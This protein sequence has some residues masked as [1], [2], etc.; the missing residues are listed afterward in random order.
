MMAAEEPT[1]GTIG[2]PEPGPAGL[3]GLS[4][5]GVSRRRQ[6]VWVLDRLSARLLRVA[7]DPSACQVSWTADGGLVWVE[8]AGRGGTR[9]M[10]APRL[11]DDPSVLIDLPGRHSHEYFPRVS[12]DGRWL[13]WGASTGGHEHDRADYEIFIW[14]I[15]TPWNTATR[16]T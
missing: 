10:Q 4:L 1:R 16:V 12:A 11:G 7:E 8:A 2:D 5:R 6:G 3:I 9:V 15:G 13:I 14:R